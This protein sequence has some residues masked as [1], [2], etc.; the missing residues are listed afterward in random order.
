[1]AKRHATARNGPAAT[2]GLT[3]K[4]DQV[5]LLMA[6]GHSIRDAAR[7]A[8]LDAIRR[9]GRKIL[10]ALI[11]EL[12]EGPKT[13]APVLEAGQ[14]ITGIPNETGNSNGYKAKAAAWKT[15]LGK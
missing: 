4:Q 1:M 8:S 9:L 12:E 5:A 11:A 14:A 15:W 6:A 13:P 10:P 2:G 7:K 3:A